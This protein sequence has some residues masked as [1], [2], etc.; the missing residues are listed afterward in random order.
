MKIEDAKIRFLRA[1]LA[2]V[3]KYLFHL[4]DCERKQGKQCT[5]GLDEVTSYFYGEK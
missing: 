5:C 3:N 2:A 4:K 1:V